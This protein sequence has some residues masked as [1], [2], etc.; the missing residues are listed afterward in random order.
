MPT[1]RL[2]FESEG[3]PTWPPTPSW[4]DERQQRDGGNRYRLL[5]RNEAAGERHLNGMSTMAAT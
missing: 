2:L 4:L 5:L 3:E 1:N